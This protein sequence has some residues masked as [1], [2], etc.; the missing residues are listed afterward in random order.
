[1][2]TTLRNAKKDLVG[3]KTVDKIH[4]SC[5]GDKFPE[6][7][8]YASDRSLESSFKLEG[9]LPTPVYG[10]EDHDYCDHDSD[11][12]D[13]GS[14]D[15]E[16]LSDDN[17]ISVLSMGSLIFRLNDKDT[18]I[19]I[20]KGSYT[21]TDLHLI[22]AQVWDPRFLD[23]E[24]SFNG[25]N[26]NS[27]SRVSVDNN[28]IVVIG[29]YL[30]GGKKSNAVTLQRNRTIIIKKKPKKRQLQRLSV[31]AVK[32]VTVRGRSG[33]VSNS[34]MKTPSQMQFY[35][36]ITQ[37]FAPTTEGCKV[38]D[39]FNFPTVTA[40]CH[41]EFQLSTNAG[42]SVAHALV[43]P[44]PMAA[45][46]CSFG[47]ITSSLTAFGGQANLFYFASR[48]T[49]N[50]LFDMYRTVAVGVKISNLQPELTATGRVIV[51]PLII[52]R[53]CPGFDMLNSATPGISYYS[54]VTV[55]LTAAQTISGALINKPSSVV[56]P[57]SALL[58]ESIQFSSVPV[59]HEF[60]C[61]K[62]PGSLP[63]NGS[64]QQIIQDGENY[65]NTIT[66]LVTNVT[67][68]FSKNMDMSG[69]VALNIL[70]EGA[71]VSTTV[72][73]VEVIVHLEGTPVVGISTNTVT[74]SGAEAYAGS[75][76]M[77][78][79]ALQQAAGSSAFRVMANG[80]QFLNNG[81][82][83]KIMAGMKAIGY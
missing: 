3:F 43:F 27:I 14:V 53:E 38:P 58:R 52:G 81:G 31:V 51:T 20:P 33:G 60:Y 66:G 74:M 78:E 45:V 36:A 42:N 41:Y 63:F 2:T 13:E 65:F 72:L 30:L 79:Q 18:K 12:M 71:P 29:L 57:V 35:K 8:S 21:H 6:Q 25:I 19:F 26:S 1:M 17:V 10:V 61:F 48:S 77:V 59:N 56:I 69:G 73:Q 32:K 39:T 83:G 37:P 75:T 5:S 4:Q 44:G 22:L 50:G 49:I 23:V 11:S 80:F 24:C 47:S 82:G 46:L 68:E 28:T 70:M 15:N 34:N 7:N 40:H 54:D 76:A 9:S 64:S 16:M 67:Q 62:N 55:G